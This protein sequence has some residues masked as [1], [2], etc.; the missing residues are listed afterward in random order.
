MATSAD[1]SPGAILIVEDNDEDFEATVR[2]FRKSG[3]AN[4]LYRCVDG[5]DAI[6]FLLRQGCYGPPDHAPRPNVILLDLNL[7]GT[8]GYE[9]LTTIKTTPSLHDIPVIVLTTSNDNRDIDSCYKVG[10]SSYIQKPVDLS[11]FIE[12]VQRLTDYRFKIVILP[13]KQGTP[14]GA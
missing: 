6:D 13:T 8:D 7:P 4:V 9:V 3:V 14:T 12:A 10:A 11:G 5:E 1:N 2:A